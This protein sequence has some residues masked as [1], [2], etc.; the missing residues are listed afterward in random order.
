MIQINLDRQLSSFNNMDAIP[1]L[2]EV[3]LII[4]NI[5][6]KKQKGALMDTPRQTEK[7]LL[8]ITIFI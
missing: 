6:S 8:G 1:W 7:E 3:L 2:P 4:I 5:G